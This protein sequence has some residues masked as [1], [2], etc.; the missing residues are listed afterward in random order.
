MK[1]TLKRLLYQL[2][3][4]TGVAAC[5]LMLLWF[6]S[7]IVMLFVGYPKLTP[8]ERLANMPALQPA[9][10]CIGP[11]PLMRADTGA[12]TLTTS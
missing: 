12:I 6:I 10:C 1:L 11:D 4:W 9:T 2:H 3:R 8:W 5:V 7:G